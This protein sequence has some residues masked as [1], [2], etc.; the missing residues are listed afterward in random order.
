[1]R[2]LV[3]CAANPAT[4]PRPSRMIENLKEQHVVTAMGLDS[5]AISGVEVLSYSSYT[6]RNWLK[7]CLLWMHVILRHWNSLIFTKNRLE[8]QAFLKRREFDL[9][10]C[11]DLV[12]LPIVLKNKKDAKV[13]FDA[14]EFYPKQYTN[15]LRWRLLFERFNDFLCR[16]YMP[17]AD[18]IVTV[19][20]GIQE[21]YKRIYGIE[22]EVFYSLSQ[23]HD[24][25]PSLM[26]D[27]QIRMLYH[28]SANRAREIE[29]TI[30]IIDYC[31]DDFSLDLM[32][33]CQD[34]AYLKKLEKMVAKR[35]DLGKKIRIIPPVSFA[36]LIT[37]SNQYDIG[38]YALVANNFNLEV[39]MP[40]KFFEYM[41]SRLALAIFPHE[42]ME[43]FLRRY[44]NGIIAKEPSPLS[45]AQAL[46]TLSKKDIMQMK[47]KSHI[48]AKTLHNDQNKQRM[49]H[50]L[51]EMFLSLRI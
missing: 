35:Q 40:N 49:Q 30:E 3:L 51:R 19:G 25:A 5:S 8:I 1:M 10:I 41:Q 14:R 9:I 42:E 11:H 31:R 23:Y 36:D 17:Q 24:I 7:E 6:K 50:L 15:S 29:R 18:K 45:L 39:A 46:N 33:V 48:I 34:K 47:I 22:S 13:L 44:K 20:S 2:I 12:L 26:E 4:N 32:L 37:F 28:G 38:I 27:A 43:Q 16:F 21:A